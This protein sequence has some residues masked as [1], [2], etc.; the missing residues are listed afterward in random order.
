MPT[1]NPKRVREDEASY[2][3]SSPEVQQLPKRP[4]RFLSF[5]EA[6]PGGAPRRERGS[7]APPPALPIVLPWF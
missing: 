7:S 4:R 2:G 6:F 1:P 3:D 5:R